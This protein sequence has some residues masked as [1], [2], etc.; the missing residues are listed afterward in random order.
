MPCNY[1]FLSQI[2]HPSSLAV[3]IMAPNDHMDWLPGLGNPHQGRSNSGFAPRAELE[4][5]LNTQAAD[6]RVD[7]VQY[8]IV[9]D[10]CGKHFWSRSKADSHAALTTHVLHEEIISPCPTMT[11]PE[12]PA[13]TSASAPDTATLFTCAKQAVS[14]INTETPDEEDSE[15]EEHSLCFG[16]GRHFWSHEAADNHAK[17]AHLQDTDM[18]PSIAPDRS[19]NLGAADPTA[20]PKYSAASP[21]VGSSSLYWNTGPGTASLADNGAINPTSPN[22]T[23]KQIFHPAISPTSPPVISPTSPLYKEGV[24]PSSVKGITCPT[25]GRAMDL[26]RGP[27]SRPGLL[28]VS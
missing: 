6:S 7:E 14:S 1:I 16:C 21:S 19:S 22:W 23:L 25:S 24:S 4:T 2:I 3:T 17:T 8:S 10:D 26:F 18:V 28:N 15:D 11:I 5:A 27:V 13:A 20:T 12:F 9:C